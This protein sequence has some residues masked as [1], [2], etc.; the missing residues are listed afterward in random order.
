L[1]QQFPLAAVF[2]AMKLLKPMLALAAIVLPLHEVAAADLR[3]RVGGGAEIRPEYPGAD[4]LRIGFDPEFGVAR[5][6]EPFGLGA[7]DDRFNIKL[8]SSGGFSAGPSAGLSPSRRDS[9][10]G[11]PVGDVSRAIELGGF[12]QYHFGESF[13]V[14]AEARHA[15][16][17]HNGLTGY[18]GADY[19]TRDAD[20]YT[21]SIGPRIRFGDAG[22]MNSYFGVSPEVSIK[23]LLPVYRPSGGMR[24]VGAVSGFTY[25]LGG[26]FGLYGFARYDRLV[27][28]AKSSPIARQ[29]GSPDQFAAG[30]GLTYTFNISL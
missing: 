23:T 9:D 20:R 27:G 15:L 26:P 7:P 30:L 2:A 6:D 18:L 10:V 14:R 3:I 16:G 4:S 5:G 25:S 17:G 13:R 28:G 29:F 12:A 8:F 22:Y 19:F 1:A 24:A 11:A 21:F